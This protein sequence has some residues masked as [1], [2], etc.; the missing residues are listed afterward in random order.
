MSD[1]KCS[2]KHDV[3]YH[4]TTMN[5]FRGIV[6]T[7]TLWATHYK[8]LNDS[9]ELSRLTAILPDFLVPT[10]KRVIKEFRAEGISVKQA[11]HEAGS[12]HELARHEAIALSNLFFEAAFTPINDSK[13]PMFEPFITSFCSHLEDD[14]YTRDNGLLSMW[15]SYG[16]DGGVALV[17]D[18]AILENCL[19]RENNE[20]DHSFLSIGDV[21]YEGDSDA[22]RSEFGDLIKEVQKK[23]YSH[24]KGEN[25]NF[26]GILGPFLSSVARLKHQAFKEEREVRIITMPWNERIQGHE[27]SKDAK[28][29]SELCRPGKNG[30]IRFLALFDCEQV[31]RL[32]IR[33]IIVGPHREQLERYEEI[34]RVTRHL[35]HIDVTCSETPLVER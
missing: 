4:Y 5:G 29:K 24:L 13:L 18:A 32:P 17:M 14:E 12:R 2:D 35:E 6:D 34:I 3:L 31:P 19:A 23:T 28:L 9:S 21:V 7:Q 30:T 15:R 1:E 16:S 20:Y 27:R 25:A 22:F 11:I 26:G 33:K 10:V 8:H